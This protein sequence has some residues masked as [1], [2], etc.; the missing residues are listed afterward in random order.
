M[1]DTWRTALS[2]I[3]SEQQSG[4]EFD[5]SRREFVSRT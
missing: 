3:V 5:F 4:K 1:D 2:I